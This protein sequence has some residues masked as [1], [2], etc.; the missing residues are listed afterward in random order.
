MKL[1]KEILNKVKD[2]HNNFWGVFEF[3]IDAGFNEMDSFM[4]SLKMFDG[5]FWDGVVNVEVDFVR[6]LVTEEII[7]PPANTTINY[8]ITNFE[9]REGLKPTPPKTKTE[10]FK[11]L[12]KFK[13][14]G[15]KA[16][17]IYNGAGYSASIDPASSGEPIIS[18]LP[19]YKEVKKLKVTN[20]YKRK[21]KITIINDKG[22]HGLSE[23]YEYYNKPR[24]GMGKKIDDIET[25]SF[26]IEISDNIINGFIKEKLVFNLD[27]TNN[28]NMNSVMGGCNSIAVGISATTYQGVFNELGE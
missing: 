13:E 21:Y 23:F 15:Y 7:V 25:K 24:F 4:E 14:E 8:D 6:E 22:S 18:A 16:G 28:N 20:P 2:R 12:F 11:S 9:R 1:N 17:K 10:K 27:K 19:V 5:N 3:L 26:E